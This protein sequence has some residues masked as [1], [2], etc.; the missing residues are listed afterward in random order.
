MTPNDEPRGPERAPAARGTPVLPFLLIVIGALLL[1]GQFGWIDWF[2]WR[3][4]IDL[5]NLWPLALIALGIDILTRGRWRLWI[6]GGTLVAGVIAVQ[7]FGLTPGG[8]PI[9]ERTIA[10]DVAEVDR[11]RVE[12]AHGVGRLEIGTL[13]AG[14]A[15]LIEGVIRVGANESVDPTFRLQDGGAVVT[16]RSRGSTVSGPVRGAD[17]LWD[18]DLARE[19]P[20]DLRL[21]GGVGASRL[22]LR[23]LTLAALHVSAGVGEVIVDLPARGGYRGVIEAGVGEVTVRIPESVEA[24]VEA[25]AGL[26]GVAVTGS[27][28]RDGSVHRTAG[29]EDAAVE[30]RIDLRVSGGIGQIRVERVD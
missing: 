23:E 4:L 28:D 7:V 19:V 16:V 30:D 26:G 27:W 1:A 2:D 12:L 14:D 29:Y 8:G 20:I 18:L 5:A 10:Y 24:H 15:R 25:E 3:V 17:R 6:V 11:A 21:D 22:S 9:V 13:A